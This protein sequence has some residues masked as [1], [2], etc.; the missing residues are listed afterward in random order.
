MGVAFFYDPSAVS[1]HAFGF[2]VQGFAPDTMV[3]IE[4]MSDQFVSEVGVDGDVARSK[5]SDRRATITFS[6]MQT[7]P[8]NALLSAQLITDQLAPNGAGVGDVRVADTQGG[9]YYTGAQCWIRKWPDAE[10]ARSAKTREWAIEV[11]DLDRF[12]GGNAP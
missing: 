6:L 4:M 8:T 9:S 1:M 10:M 7:S 11:A 2:P 3:K 5:V 12:E